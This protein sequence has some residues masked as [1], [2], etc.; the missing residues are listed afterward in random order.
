[1]IEGLVSEGARG[2]IFKN[3][4]VISDEEY[5]KLEYPVF[6]G[7]DFGFSNDPTALI[8][9]KEHNNK[10]Y[11]RELI[12]ETGLTN[13]RISA[14]MK[15]EGVSKNTIIYGD[16]AEPKSIEEIKLEGWNIESSVKGQDSVKAGIDML[17]DKEVYY[18]ESS[19]NIANEVQEYIWL[20]NREKEPTNEPIDQF[21]HAMDA[22]RG[23]IFTKSKQP[24]IGF[25]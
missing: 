12:Y 22:V 11:L 18:T 9:I 21:N 15:R 25:A 5:E 8:E 23:A 13:Q 2:R 6:N 1:M 14:R 4:K 20:L 16:A 3:W 19:V 10:I 24:F 17:L 7:L